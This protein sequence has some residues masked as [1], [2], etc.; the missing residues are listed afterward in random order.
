MQ[1]GTPLFGKR[2]ND[3][4]KKDRTLPVKNKQR[5][6]RYPLYFALPNNL[7][8]TSNWGPG[9]VSF[10]GHREDEDLETFCRM[11]KI[12][13]EQYEEVRDQECRSWYGKE[14]PLGEDDGV[15][16]YTITNESVLGNTLCPSDNYIKTIA[17]GLKETYNFTVEE[18]VNY[19]IVKEGIRDNLQKEEMIKILSFLKN[20]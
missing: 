16:I 5:I 15:P 1:G 7:K 12:T 17:V 3:G 10:I 6:I 2:K 14:M 4:C 19:L 18:I 11:W 13:K 20:A 8:E 9:G